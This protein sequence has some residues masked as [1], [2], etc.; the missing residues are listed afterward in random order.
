MS[1]VCSDA[2]LDAAQMAELDP[3]CDNERCIPAEAVTRVAVP[4]SG[5]RYRRSGMTAVLHRLGYVY[6]KKDKL[7]PGRHPVPEVQEAVGEN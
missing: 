3:Y 2:L 6:K 4:R 5:E 7:E 1:Y